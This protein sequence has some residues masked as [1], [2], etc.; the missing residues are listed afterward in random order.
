MPEYGGGE[1]TI[2]K[3]DY[4]QRYVTLHPPTAHRD[5]NLNNVHSNTVTITL[6]HNIHIHW[7]HV[8]TKLSG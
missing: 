1:K 5:N 2:W 8:W 3:T 7:N 4:N 6:H